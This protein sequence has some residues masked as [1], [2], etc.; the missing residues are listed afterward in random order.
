MEKRGLSPVIA[1][2]L[3]LTLTIIL[4]SIVFLWAKGF[5]SE[6]ILKFN[7]PVELQCEK[8]E[9]KVNVL[10]SSLGYQLEISNRGSIPIYAFTISRY[11]LGES[12]T[13][14]FAINVKPGESEIQTV[15]LKFG[16]GAVDSEYV[17]FA[18]SILGVI[19]G[20]DDDETKSYIC[21]TNV[22]RYTL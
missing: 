1:T 15:S 4:A 3:L 10:K 2:A 9:W 16:E 11:L 5:I 20:S 18:P 8:V 17:E 6:Q 19:S 7:Q 14:Q 22:K 13:E 12:E 21:S